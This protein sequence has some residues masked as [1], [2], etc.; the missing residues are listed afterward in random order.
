MVRSFPTRSAQLFLCRFFEKW[1]VA[2]R[3][4]FYPF[5]LLTFHRFGDH[6]IYERQLFYLPGLGWV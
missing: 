1:Q 5:L 3:L 6:P 2:M 4:V